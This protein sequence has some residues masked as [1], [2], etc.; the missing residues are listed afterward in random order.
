MTASLLLRFDGDE[1]VELLIERAGR[2][3]LPPYIA[4][5]R[6]ADA[7][8]ESDY[9]TMFASEKGAVAAPT[10]LCISRRN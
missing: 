5:K 2:M 10:A 8:D 4:G 3:P 9:Q 7:Q 6:A 1:P